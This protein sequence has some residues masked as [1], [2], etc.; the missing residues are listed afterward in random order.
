MPRQR[1]TPF[2]GHQLFA[3]IQDFLATY[4]RVNATFVQNFQSNKRWTFLLSI[5]TENSILV[6]VCVCFQP[7]ENWL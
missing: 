6:C 7:E 2:E 1:L 5:H 3:S 4:I